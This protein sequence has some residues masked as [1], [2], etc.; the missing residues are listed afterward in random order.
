MTQARKS[1]SILAGLAFTFTVA[2]AMATGALVTYELIKSGYDSQALR[3]QQASGRIGDEVREGYKEQHSRRLKSYAAAAAAGVSPDGLDGIKSEQDFLARLYE[4]RLK[5]LQ[6]ESSVRRAALVKRDGTLL[7]DT[8]GGKFGSREFA[9]DANELEACFTSGPVVTIEY[10]DDQG[11]VYRNAFAAVRN[12]ETGAVSNFAVAVELEAEY[13]DGLNLMRARAA[14]EREQQNNENTERLSSLR[15][16]LASTVAIV[17]VVTLGAALF[18]ARY[19]SRLLD[20][21]AKQKRLAE[22]AQFSSGMAHQIKNPLAAMRG[23]AELIARTLEDPMQKKMSDK[24]VAEIAALDRVV[25]DFLAFSRGAHGSPERISLK[26]AL[27]PIVDA[28]RARAGE[29]VK[30]EL[31]CDE[32]S[33]NTE[34]DIDTTSLRQALLNLGV[35]AAEA[36]REIDAPGRKLAIRASVNGQLTTVD[37]EDNGP[38]IAEEVRGKLFEPFVTG[39]ADGTGLGLAISRRLLRDLGGDL[40]LV[41]SASTGTMFRATFSK[42]SQA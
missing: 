31:E 6:G 42:R 32:A 39:K 23:Y 27:A 41:R 26:T 37:F 2:A 25:R 14:T 28:A 16:T 21:L 1:Q 30:V 34:L 18:M 20:E 3:R 17:F 12:L 38:G 11:R 10:K 9:Q 22:L 7:V 15:L 8:A 29:A 36:M 24:L 4:R 33:G 13:L 35:N 40:V 5:A 19:E